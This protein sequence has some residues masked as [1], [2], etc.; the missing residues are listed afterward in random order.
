VLGHAVSQT[1]GAGAAV[2]CWREALALLTDIGT[3]EADQV[4]ACSTPL[5]P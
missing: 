2:S 4:R 1:E 5:A 3:P